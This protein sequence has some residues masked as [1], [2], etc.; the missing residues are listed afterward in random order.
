MRQT[1]RQTRQTRQRSWRS[2]RRQKRLELPMSS[3]SFSSK[4]GVKKVFL[5]LCRIGRDTN[6]SPNVGT[7]LLQFIAAIAATLHKVKLLKSLAAINCI[8]RYTLQPTFG[9][10]SLNHIKISYKKRI[11]NTKFYDF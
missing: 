7:K 2:W 3:N 11:L 1:R 5:H 10:L 4:S 6:N 8:C 9:L